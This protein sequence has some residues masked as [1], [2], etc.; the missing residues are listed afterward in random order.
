MFTNALCSLSLCQPFTNGTLL[1]VT[2]SSLFLPVSELRRKGTEEEER[3]PQFLLVGG[4]RSVVENGPPSLPLPQ[5]CHVLPASPHHRCLPLLPPS[6]TVP[7]SPL[8][9]LPSFSIPLLTLPCTALW[10]SGGGSKE[11]RLRRGGRICLH[12]ME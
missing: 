12:I 1:H 10:E 11:H 5:P 6:L 8:P 9:Y 4:R 3:K 7:L 2:P